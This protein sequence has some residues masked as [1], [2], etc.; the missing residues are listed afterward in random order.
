[1]SEWGFYFTLKRDVLY[2]LWVVRQ[3]PLIPKGFCLDLKRLVVSHLMCSIV[4]NTPWWMTFT[5]NNALSMEWTQA[6][7]LETTGW[8]KERGK[9]HSIKLGRAVSFES[10]LSQLIEHFPNCII[11]LLVVRTKKEIKNLLS[12]LSIRNNSRINICLENSLHKVKEMYYDFVF[13]GAATLTV[14]EEEKFAHCHIL[15]IDS[16]LI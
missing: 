1:M 14:E 11:V 8:M 16:D 7:R 10:I 12:F 13:L 5:N 4:V 3:S 9:C 15:N 6:R 2:W